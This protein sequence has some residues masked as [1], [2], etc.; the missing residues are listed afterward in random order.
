MFKGFTKRLIVNLS[1]FRADNIWLEWRY[2]WRTLLYDM[3]DIENAINSVDS[4]LKRVRGQKGYSDEYSED[5]S[6]DTDY[7]G[8]AYCCGN[9]WRRDGIRRITLRY[10][11]A[12][13]ADVDPPE[14]YVNP[15][16]TGWEIITLSFV[17]DWVYNIGQFLMSL[18][19]VAIAR[20]TVQA[21]GCKVTVV[22]SSYGS[23]TTKGDKYSGNSWDSS[24]F[25]EELTIRRP[26]SPLSAPH[27]ALNLNVGRITDL[28]ALL[29]QVLTR[30]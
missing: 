9:L 15:L 10:H 12:A 26:A 20:G 14:I 6:L 16:V 28:L 24:A 5:L 8:G 29:G 3:Q 13:V 19:T 11:G 7:Y 27:L 2:G 25:S 1:R 4:G 18:S 23:W 21:G 22:T 30:R 17:V